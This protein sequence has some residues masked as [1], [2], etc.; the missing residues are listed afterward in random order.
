[1]STAE[2]FLK[3][4]QGIQGAAKVEN[5]HPG[6]GSQ[7]VTPLVFSLFREGLLDFIVHMNHLVKMQIL[8]Q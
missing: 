4:P 3:A 7:G 1:M 2:G 8:A 6:E 5:L